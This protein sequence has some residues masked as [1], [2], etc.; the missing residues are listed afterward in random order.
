MLFL[1]L[2]AGSPI[3]IHKMSLN[4]DDVGVYVLWVQLEWFVPLFPVTHYLTPLFEHLSKY[5][6]TFAFS[7]QASVTALIE[8]SSVCCLLSVFWWW[9]NE[10]AAV[11]SYL[12]D[13]NPWDIYLWGM[14]MDRMDSS[15]LHSENNAAPPPTP[16][17]QYFQFY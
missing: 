1:C 7:L 8:V 5:D 9:N 2:S 13:V 14:L 16:Q 6:R 3:L 15:N 11:V 4:D 10:Q 17:M 12:P